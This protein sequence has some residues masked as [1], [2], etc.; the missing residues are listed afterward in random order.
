[1][2]LDEGTGM[3]PQKVEVFF[4]AVFFE[5][6]WKKDTG[7]VLDYLDFFLVNELGFLVFFWEKILEFQKWHQVDFRVPKLSDLDIY[8][9][10]CEA[11][12]G[13]AYVR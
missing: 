7:C 6:G 5:D 11:E 2:G 3:E 12:L 1:M 8:V 9:R 10:L 4:H 13:I